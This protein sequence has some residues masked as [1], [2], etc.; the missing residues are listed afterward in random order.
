ML[1]WIPP[2]CCV[3][4]SEFVTNCAG[5]LTLTIENQFGGLVSFYVNGAMP[6]VTSANV[7]CADIITFNAC[8]TYSDEHKTNFSSAEGAC[9]SA[10]TFKQDNGPLVMGNTYHMYC[11]EEEVND[12]GLYLDRFY[13]ATMMAHIRAIC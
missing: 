11:L 13:M 2:E 12:Y 3:A 1:L 4:V 6:R 5:T 10:L 8:L 7:M 9:W